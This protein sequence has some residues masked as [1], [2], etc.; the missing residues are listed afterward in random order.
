MVTSTLRI[1]RL[2]LQYVTIIYLTTHFTAR[3]RYSSTYQH[4]PHMLGKSKLSP[5]VGNLAMAFCTWMSCCQGIQKELRMDGPI[6]KFSRG[7]WNLLLPVSFWNIYWYGSALG[8]AIRNCLWN[9]YFTTPGRGI[10]YSFQL[11]I[12]ALLY[13]IISYCITSAQSYFKHTM[14]FIMLIL[15]KQNACGSIFFIM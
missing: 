11:A 5:Y 9:R 6:W 2:I 4:W 14:A 3:S 8:R 13:S 7:F 12:T 10:G 15:I 1:F